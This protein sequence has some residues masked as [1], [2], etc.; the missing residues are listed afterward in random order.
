MVELLIKEFV[1]IRSLISFIVDKYLILSAGWTESKSSI[2]W[3][4][5]GL[6]VLIEV[7]I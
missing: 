2:E 1:Q 3:S 5:P 7:L 6:P 4:V